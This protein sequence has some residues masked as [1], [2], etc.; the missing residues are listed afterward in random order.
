MLIHEASYYDIEQT[1]STL[2]KLPQDLF[3]LL[4]FSLSLHHYITHPSKFKPLADFPYYE[5]D[6]V[7]VFLTKGGGDA[8]SFR[9]F[10]I[11]SDNFMQ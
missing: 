11:R 3:A 9:V 6:Q 5:I 2:L 1:S 8:Q 10:P 7:Y 4:V